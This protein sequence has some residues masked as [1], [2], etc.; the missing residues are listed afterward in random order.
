MRR[1]TLSARRW[2]P[3]V[4]MCLPAALDR[5]RWASAA[6]TGFRGGPE[7]SSFKGAS[8]PGACPA[9][10]GRC[11]VPLGEGRAVDTYPPAAINDAGCGNGPRPF[12]LSPRARNASLLVSCW[13]LPAPS[14]RLALRARGGNGGA[15]SRRI[16]PKGCFMR[17]SFLI[18]P[19]AKARDSFLALMVCT[20]STN[21]KPRQWSQGLWS[22]AQ[23]AGGRLSAVAGC[24]KTQSSRGGGQW[25]GGSEQGNKHSGDLQ[26][27][28][29]G[30][31]CARCG[32]KQER[33]D[34]VDVPEA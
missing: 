33:R 22:A 24:V 28:F 18:S 16:C 19:W 32:L 14:S 8:P 12:G 30:G 25:S 21:R 10:G 23:G 13:C 15:S 31:R 2:A 17:R 34:C 9:A 20:Y 11:C 26:G 1:A 5:L 4:R 27:G 7:A 6:A 3:R 29:S